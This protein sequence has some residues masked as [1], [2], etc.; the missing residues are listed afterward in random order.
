MSR[1]K[2][3]SRDTPCPRIPMDPCFNYSH[4]LL[5][6][7]LVNKN[8]IRANQYY[9]SIDWFLVCFL[10][11]VSEVQLRPISVVQTYAVMPCLLYFSD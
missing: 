10:L 6:V 11:P 8:I 1:N 2:R 9:Q 5:S 3:D 7:I 4:R